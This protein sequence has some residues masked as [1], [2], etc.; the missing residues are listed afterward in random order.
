MSLQAAGVAAGVVQNAAALFRDPQHQARGFWQSFENH[1]MFGTR[2][3]DRYPARWSESS[4]EP[5]LRS[6][7][8]G[9]HTFEVFA[10]LCAMT[11]EEVA[12]GIGDGL[13]A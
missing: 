10:E 9:E 5:Y 7:Y 1:P 13:F 2:P 8:F 11:V 4:L 6:P 3:F 12:T